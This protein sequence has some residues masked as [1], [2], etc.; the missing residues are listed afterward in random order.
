M[1][2]LLSPVAG[3]S[4]YCPKFSPVFLTFLPALFCCYFSLAQTPPCP[5]PPNCGMNPQYF[6]G[7]VTDF[8][9]VMI[10]NGLG[11]YNIAVRS[12]ATSTVPTTYYL[13]SGTTVIATLNGTQGVF[14]N[15]Q[16]GCYTV[17]I[18]TDGDIDF[19]CS[20]SAGRNRMLRTVLPLL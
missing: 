16:P 1:R 8:N 12:I 10:P 4:S 14:E 3:L 17:I 2:N 20:M 9:W 7:E 15:I 11:Q 5:P 19:Y 13:M 6:C 18:C